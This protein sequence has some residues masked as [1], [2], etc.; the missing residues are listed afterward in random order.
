MI[1]ALEMVMDVWSSPLGDYHPDRHR[2]LVVY[3]TG[4]GVVRDFPHLKHRRHKRM[5]MLINPLC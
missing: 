5:I 4:R 3:R 1:Y 2:H